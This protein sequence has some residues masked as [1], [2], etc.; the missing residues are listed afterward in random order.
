[1]VG[2]ACYSSFMHGYRSIGMLAAAIMGILGGPMATADQSDPRLA[3]LFSDLRSAPNAATAEEVESRI[4]SIWSETGDAELD[5][6][7]A[8]GTRALTVG[9]LRTALK[10]FDVVVVKAP[11][12]AEG[13][14]KRATIHY[15]LGNFERSLADIDRTLALEPN[16][17]GAISG[18]GLVNLQLE[19]DEAALAAFERVLRVSPQSAGARANIEFVKQ[20]IKDKSI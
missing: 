14:N 8:I 1:M 20:R 15:L 13:W 11:N 4:W 6:V 7:Y 3:G 18:L 5:A 19:N 12:F 17:F 16:H 2:G 9:D 10:V